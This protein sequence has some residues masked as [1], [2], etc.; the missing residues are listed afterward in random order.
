MVA[1]LSGRKKPDFNPGTRLT[2]TLTGTGVEGITIE[3]GRTT[4]GRACF[5][6]G[7]VLDGRKSFRDYESRTTLTLAHCVLKSRRSD[8]KW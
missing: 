3:D 7:L 5:L 2:L 6:L 8:F 4:P 1:V